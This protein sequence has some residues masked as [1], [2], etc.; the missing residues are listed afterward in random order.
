LRMRLYLLCNLGPKASNVP[1]ECPLLCSAL[2]YLYRATQFL[3]N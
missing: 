3:I 2:C 1:L